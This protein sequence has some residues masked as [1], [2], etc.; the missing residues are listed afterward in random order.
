[1]STST[2]DES[3]GSEGTAQIEAMDG[4]CERR[5]WELAGIVRDVR[6]PGRQ[7]RSPGLDHALERVSEGEAGTNSAIRTEPFSTHVVE[8]T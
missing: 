8:F 4:F 7:E 3:N 5:G 2:A 6:T 1:M